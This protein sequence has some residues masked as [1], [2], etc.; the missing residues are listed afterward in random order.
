MKSLTH[1]IICFYNSTF[2]VERQ[3][4]IFLQCSITC[5]TKEGVGKH[6]NLDIVI[7]KNAGT[8]GSKTT[9]DGASVVFNAV[10]DGITYAAP[11]ISE[12]EGTGA[13]RIANTAGNELLVIRGANFGPP[14]PKPCKWINKAELIELQD[15]TFK[16]I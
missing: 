8:T 2:F 11:L 14:C 7:Y 5:L 3:N 10:D 4:F 15:G 13:E 16:R 6:L 1:S 12:Y 9:T